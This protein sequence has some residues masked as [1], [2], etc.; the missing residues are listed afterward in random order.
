[1]LRFGVW[2]HWDNSYKTLDADYKT[3]ELGLFGLLWD[4]V[5]SKTAEDT[6]MC[7]AKRVR[8]KMHMDWQLNRCHMYFFSLECNEVSSNEL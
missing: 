2:G 8:Q 6:R 5:T 1:M 7:K 3:D 4:Q